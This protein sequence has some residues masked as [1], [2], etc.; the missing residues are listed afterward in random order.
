M[1]STQFGQLL[2]QAVPVPCKE[3]FEI[4]KSDIKL[5][6]IFHL[7][8]YPSKESNNQAKLLLQSPLKTIIPKETNL[9]NKKMEGN[10]AAKNKAK[11][12]LTPQLYAYT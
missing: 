5:K 9:F 4:W 7:S 12:H 10:Q 11:S 6:V 8:S 2:Q 1:S 3:L